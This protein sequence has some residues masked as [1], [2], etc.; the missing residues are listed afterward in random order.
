L[1]RL[2]S[3][4]MGRSGQEYTRFYLA[5]TEHHKRVQ[6]L[7][8]DSRHLFVEDRE[9]QLASLLESGDS[10]LAEEAGKLWGMMRLQSKDCSAYPAPRPNIHSVQVLALSRWRSLQKDVPLLLNAATAHLNE[11]G[12][13]YQLFVYGSSR[14]LKQPFL[15]ADFEIVERVKHLQ[16]DHLSRRMRQLQ[17]SD[18][19]QSTV[20]ICLAQA[21][22][23]IALAQLDAAAFDPIWHWPEPALGKLNQT[24]HVQVAIHDGQLAGYSAL[25]LHPPDFAH[26]ARLAVAPALQGQRLGQQLLLSALQYAHEHQVQSVGLN[27]QASNEP[28]QRLYH[29]FGFRPTG[30][31]DP[32]LV[33]AVI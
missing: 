26:L 5:T 30:Q 33:K 23:Y 19:A 13:P 12:S 27:T 9:L 8:D 16:L 1:K 6:A 3:W 24:H 21:D 29:A 4:L 28:A 25:R 2:G 17:S 32:I 18:V 11:A 7:L 20:K 15:Q 14:W 22:D 31:T 10:W